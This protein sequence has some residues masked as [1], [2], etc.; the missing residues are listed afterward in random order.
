MSKL[1]PE[2]EITFSRVFEIFAQNRLELRGGEG[3]LGQVGVV[4]VGLFDGRMLGCTVGPPELALPVSVLTDGPKLALAR[5]HE[6]FAERPWMRRNIVI[7]QIVRSHLSLSTF[8]VGV[9]FSQI[10]LDSSQ[11]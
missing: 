5:R 3:G 8:V 4:V 11:F 7:N 10:L 9:D 2:G 6:V 1:A